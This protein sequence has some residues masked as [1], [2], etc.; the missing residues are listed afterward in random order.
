MD[1]SIDT[2]SSS[3][4]SYILPLKIILPVE[5]VHKLKNKD[6]FERFNYILLKVD[7]ISYHE[8]IHSDNSDFLL[9][10]EKKI[11]PTTVKADAENENS[12]E[13]TENVPI[14]IKVDKSGSI[15]HSIQSNNSDPVLVDTQGYRYEFGKH[16]QI[17][18]EQGTS[19]IEFDE[20]EIEILRS[21]NSTKP[22]NEISKRVLSDDQPQK[23]VIKDQTIPEQ[24]HNNDDRTRHYSKISQWL[25]YHL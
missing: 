16:Y 19:V 18:N 17:K 13:T 5:H 14:L 2:E 20:I 21:E 8:H 10:V 9:P 11:F 4:S 1:D 3:F 7:D 25:H 24:N 23:D 6:S 22:H 12:T 15:S